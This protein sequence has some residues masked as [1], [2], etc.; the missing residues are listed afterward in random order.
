MALLRFS[1]IKALKELSSLDIEDIHVALGN[2]HTPELHLCE[3]L[4]RNSDLLN[5]ITKVIQHF[6]GDDYVMCHDC[7]TFD[8]CRY[9][10][11]DPVCDSCVDDNYFTSDF[12]GELFAAEFRL[13]PVFTETGEETWAESE[14]QE[15]GWTCTDTGNYFADGMPSYRTEEGNLIC[16]SAYDEGDYYQCDDCDVVSTELRYILNPD[17]SERNVCQSCYGSNYH[18][19]EVHDEH[20]HDDYQC[21]ND[22]EDEDTSPIKNYSTRVEDTFSWGTPIAKGKY[23]RR[24]THELWMGCELEVEVSESS[25][26]YPS[27]VASMLL[28]D[29]DKI[30]CCED[31]SLTRGFEIK[32]PP[33]NLEETKNI[34]EA[35]LASNAVDNLRSH[36]GGN[37]GLHINLSRSGL[38]QLQ[39]AKLMFFFNSKR[40][41][42]LLKALC[43]RFSSDSNRSGGGTNYS[44]ISGSPK[45]SEIT[46]AWNRWDADWSKEGKGT[47]HFI[48][49]R[50]YAYGKVRGKTGEV[51]ETR[52]SAVNFSSQK[53]EIRLPRG[54]LKRN[55]LLANLEMAAAVV[56]FTRTG[57][58]G[59]GSGRYA[60]E[61][62]IWM[63]NRP[64]V[65][66]DFP[67]LVKFCVDR[68]F[69]GK[70]VLP[71]KD[72]REIPQQLEIAIEAPQIN[73]QEIITHQYRSLIAAATR[74]PSL[75]LL[76]WIDL[77]Q[78]YPAL[79]A[80]QIRKAQN[81]VQVDYA[82]RVRQQW[83][84]LLA[85]ETASPTTGEMDGILWD[86]PD[87]ETTDV[88]YVFELAAA[89]R[90]ETN[91]CPP[92][93][94]E[95][96]RQY[97]ELVSTETLI[98][99]VRPFAALR[100]EYPG[101]SI[102]DLTFGRR[103]AATP[104]DS[105]YVDQWQR[106]LEAETLAPTTGQENRILREYPDLTSLDVWTI[107]NRAARAA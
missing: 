57:E 101:L 41:E 50:G 34:F 29:V 31:G 24:V 47:A 2:K 20:E 104:Y 22:E 67:E 80:S 23:L 37:C 75:A 51:N 46:R 42:A 83:Q 92:S 48:N 35:I 44:R 82:D 62:L 8:A 26:H 56:E 32:T 96:T 86:Y 54:T 33:M 43:R 13:Y 72:V 18:Y 36:N 93:V 66:K 71:R 105:R 100:I 6:H 107:F 78:D 99:G 63:A 55:T 53:V 52:Y 65:N 19:C 28:N 69:L 9:Y 25:H 58:A 88:D 16:P 27:A 64:R 77:A 14:H 61:F 73:H 84:T 39:Q 38:S 1:Q 21:V 5:E 85:A 45:L 68:H 40:N 81:H 76:S 15:N 89:A 17:G 103:F 87:L 49:K 3:H 98:P 11:G 12:S 91:P 97:R 90:A 102:M 70:E 10:E 30:I 79:E 7:G 94:E 95:V 106:L 60:S 59:A 4:K 74:Q